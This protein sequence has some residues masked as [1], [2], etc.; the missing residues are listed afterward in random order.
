MLYAMAYDL[1]KVGVDLLPPPI[2]QGGI[3]LLGP[4]QWGPSECQLRGQYFTGIATQ[5][6]Y[7]LAQRSEERRASW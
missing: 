1:P 3:S 2:A 5:V 7:Q 6:A 4:P